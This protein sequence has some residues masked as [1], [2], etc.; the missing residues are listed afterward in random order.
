MRKHAIVV[1]V[2]LCGLLTRGTAKADLCDSPKNLI[3]NC[4]F[5]TG[6]LGPWTGSPAS[7]VGNWYGVD[8]LRRIYRHLWRL[9]RRERIH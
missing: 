1:L 2:V 6:T 4:G 8:A 9:H 7:E 5:E 3:A